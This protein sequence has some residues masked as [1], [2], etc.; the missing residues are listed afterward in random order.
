MKYSSSP[1]PSESRKDAS[2][3]DYNST[4]CTIVYLLCKIV[5]IV[6]LCD[7]SIHATKIL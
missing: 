6:L 4:Y 1:L 2:K 3:Q 7:Q 5:H